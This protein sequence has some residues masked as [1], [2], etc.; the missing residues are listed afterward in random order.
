M[1]TKKPGAK[2]RKGKPVLTPAR[3]ELRDDDV[4]GDLVHSDFDVFVEDDGQVKV[5]ARCQEGEDPAI[6]AERVRFLVEA[7]G[8]DFLPPPELPR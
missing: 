2:D 7:L 3:E 5:H 6:A 1:A 8:A 4:L